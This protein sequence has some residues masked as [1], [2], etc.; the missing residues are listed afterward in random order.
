MT[1]PAQ[2][3]H[4]AASAALQEAELRLRTVVPPDELPAW[5]DRARREE[6]AAIT[7]G[8]ETTGAYTP[9]SG[10]RLAYEAAMRGERP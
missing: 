9:G 4:A 10:F 1:T 3:S 5:L 6:D 7:R 2:R 8:I